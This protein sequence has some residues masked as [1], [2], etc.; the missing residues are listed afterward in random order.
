ML[1]PNAEK[2]EIDI[3]K[4]TE[5]VLDPTH[6][7]GKNK[8]I[9][10]S[11]ALGI[12]AKD[13]PVLRQLLLEGVRSHEARIGLRDDWGQRYTVD[14][15]LEWGTLSAIIRTGWIIAYGSAVPRLTTAYPR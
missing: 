4:L 11:S 12:T 9:L 3:R 15:R 14:F 1:L 8:A 7:E 10:W 13:A 2:A 6:R 5:Y